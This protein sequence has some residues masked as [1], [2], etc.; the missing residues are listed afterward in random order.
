M[1]LVL[2]TSLACS[3]SLAL[4][5]SIYCKEYKLPNNKKNKEVVNDDYMDF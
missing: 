5:Y 3:S 2:E 4:G 1:L